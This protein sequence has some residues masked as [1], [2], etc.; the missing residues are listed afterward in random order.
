MYE[1]LVCVGFYPQVLVHYI[2][3]RNATRG[4]DYEDTLL[5]CLL[6]VS[7]LRKLDGSPPEF[8]ERPSRLTQADVDRTED[9]IYQVN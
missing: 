3:P 7:C 2:T 8:F 6:S 1:V 9:M 4:R 5:G